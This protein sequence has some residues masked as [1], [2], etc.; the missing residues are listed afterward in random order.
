MCTVWKFRREVFLH[1]VFLMQHYICKWRNKLMVYKESILRLLSPEIILITI[2]AAILE[3]E[4]GENVYKSSYLSGVCCFMPGQYNSHKPLFCFK[5]DLR[6]RTNW[7]EGLFGV[8][9]K[10]GFAIACYKKPDHPLP[11]LRQ[12]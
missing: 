4:S 1:F 2:V 10:F 9:Y 7:E 11:L 5:V 6:E 12:H 8:F 3:E